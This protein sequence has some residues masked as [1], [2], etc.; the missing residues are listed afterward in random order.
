MPARPSAAPA[1]WIVIPVH[2]RAAVT[3]RCLDRL[4]EVGVTAWAEVL[5]A[6][7]GSTDDTP[8]MIR[9]EFPWARVIRGD[10]AWWWAGAIR[11][12]MEEAIRAG[13]QIVFWLN[14]D[15]LPD[16]GAL[17]RLAALCAE[18]Q[19]ICGGICRADSAGGM[20]Y[21]GGIIRA[22][23]PAA[24][25]LP[26]EET[27]APVEW[28]HGNLVAI[29]HSVWERLGL[30]ETLGTRHNF[31]DV[32]YTHRAHRAGVPVLL[33]P[34]AAGTA[35]TNLSASYLS[36]KDDRL[37]WPEIWRGFADPKVWWYLPGVLAFKTRMFGARGLLD[38]VW[39][40]CKAAALPAF[41]LARRPALRETQR[42][43]PSD[44]CRRGASP[45]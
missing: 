27:P 38:C 26:Q 30:P 42:G 7:D 9:E 1:V 12:G 44:G 2:N 24:V 32:E 31:A 4:R 18:R 13:A 40:L 17:A 19:G 3:R 36:W 33:V 45:E 41:K 10:G 6:D 14:D 5:V 29:H 22:R 35:A 39:L 15:T 16:A 21:S 8:R 28:L 43:V 34:N 20:T 37:S 25:T 11:A 23:W